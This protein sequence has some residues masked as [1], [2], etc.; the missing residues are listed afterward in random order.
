LPTI[1]GLLNQIETGE[2]VLP[3]IQRDFVWDTESICRLLDSVLRGYP[4]GICLL[5]DTYV[6]LQYRRFISDYV[7]EGPFVFH[8]NTEGRHL[9]LVLDG[10]QRL[11]SLNVAING[12]YASRKAYLD[13]LSGEEHDDLAEP[14]FRFHFCTKDEAASIEQR[15]VPARLL[16]ISDIFAMSPLTKMNFIEALRAQPGISTDDANRSL[17]NIDTLIHSL[18]ADENVLKVATIDQDLPAI[19]PSRK[20]EADV[21]EIFVRI[22]REGTPLTRSDLVFSLLKLNWKESAELLPDFV[23]SINR[24]NSF[25]LDTDF[26]IRSLFAVADL[27]AKIDLEVLRKKSNVEGLRRAFTPCCDAIRAAIDF[28]QQECQCASSK[29]LGGPNGLVPL[30]YYLSYCPKHVVPNGQE[31]LVRNAMY[32]LWLARPFTRYG[33]SRLGTYIRS[34]FRPRKMA[35]DNGF[36]VMRTVQWVK[37]WEGVR[38]LPGLLEK[39]SLL[40]LH[41]IQGLAGAKVQYAANAP[42]IDHIFP[43]STLREKG[44]EEHEI[45]TLANYWVLAAH[46][47]RNKSNRPPKEYFADVPDGVLKSGLIERE[48]LTYKT[49]RRFVRERLEAMVNRI[50]RRLSL[51]ETLAV[52]ELERRRSNPPWSDEE[53]VLAVDL[54]ISDG[55]LD[56][57]HEKVIALSNTLNALSIHKNKE[58]Y[59][60]FR[61]PNGVAMKLANFAAIDPKYDGVGLS[62]GGRGDR[63]VW[64]K[65]AHDRT[66]LSGRVVEIM[67]SLP[68]EV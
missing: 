13:V 21:L 9:R 63:L 52:Q 41:L 57:K 62:S 48:L 14:K 12:S 23:R 68:P 58:T 29:L 31:L 26:V 22:N 56:D 60:R 39:N 47:N 50:D 32:V 20:S 46:K 51:S 16:K 28:V 59:P 38:D 53:L 2:V 35:A 42:E 17:I 36:P 67:K 55:Q 24:D 4:V 11:Q 19:S 43:Q 30:V 44:Y 25:E 15:K 6:D 33:D 8:E 49:Y 3:A 27:G 34:D 10:Q 61:N 64:D 45:D 7:P 65:Y 40:T 18:T 66:A 1:V 37:Y 54:Y 5:W